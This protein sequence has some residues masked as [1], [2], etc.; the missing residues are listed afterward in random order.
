MEVP[1]G[2]EMP[3][4]RSPFSHLLSLSSKQLAKE[5]IVNMSDFDFSP[6]LFIKSNN[7]HIRKSGK[8]K[9]RRY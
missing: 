9:E 4:L 1:K 6:L 5:G 2:N 3:C 8:A 7:F